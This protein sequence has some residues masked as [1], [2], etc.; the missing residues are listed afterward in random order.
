MMAKNIWDKFTN[1]L[2]LEAQGGKSAAPNE[3]HVVTAA[4]MVQVAVTH[5]DFSDVEKAKVLQN[6]EEHFQLG[7]QAANDIFDNAIKCHD[8]ATDLYSLTR[9]IMKNLRQEE[10]QEI[11]RLLYRVAFADDDLDHFEEHIIAR[12]AGL[13][14]VDVR[15][16]VRIKQE[17]REERRQL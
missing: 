1:I 5:E 13:L 14:G 2:G 12:I 9:V 7:A 10:Q 3:L 4:L 8:E 15:D 11:V 17:V 16:R 6:I